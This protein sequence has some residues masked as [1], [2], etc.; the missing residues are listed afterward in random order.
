MS[1]RSPS[2]YAQVP[3]RTAASP[4]PRRPGLGSCTAVDASNGLRCKLPAHGDDN[5]AHERGRFTRV[6]A[7]GQ[8]SFPKVEELVARAT[9]RVAPGAEPGDEPSRRCWGKGDEEKRRRDRAYKRAQRAR[10]AAQSSPGVVH[11]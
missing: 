3:T 5:H 7:P 8:V 10:E 11:G 4:P 6:A 9:A 1:S 2:W